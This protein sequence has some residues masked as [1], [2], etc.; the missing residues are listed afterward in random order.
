MKE[1]AK[2]AGGAGSN[3]GVKTKERELGFKGDRTSLV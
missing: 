3:R 2:G 1:K